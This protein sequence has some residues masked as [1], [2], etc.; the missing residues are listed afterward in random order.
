MNTERPKIFGDDDIDRFS[1]N[2]MKALD[3]PSMINSL[4]EFQRKFILSTDESERDRMKQDW[5]NLAMSAAELAET[6]DELQKIEVFSPAGS[7]AR[8]LIESKLNRKD[9]AA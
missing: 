3:V 5:N 9:I 1:L 6:D 8:L 4:A 2:N 7:E